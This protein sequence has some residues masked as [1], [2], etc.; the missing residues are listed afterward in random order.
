MKVAVIGAGSF[1]TCLALLLHRNGHSVKMWSHSK[2]TC[3]A[4]QEKRENIIYLPGYKIPNDINVSNS[5]EDT[6]SDVEL[7]LFVV[8]TQVTREVLKEA[9]K[10]LSEKVWVVSASKGIEKNT[11]ALV[12]DI[13]VQELGDDAKERLFFLSGPSFAKE[14]AAGMPTA[15]TLAG[16][17]ERLIPAVQNIF[18]GKTFRA[19]GTTDVIG[20]EIAGAMKNVIALA[21][22]ITDGL[23][24]GLNSRAAIMTRGLAEIAR[25]GKELGANPVTFMGLAGMGDLVLTCT[26]SLSRN[27]TVGLKLGEGKTLEEI[28]KD[29]RMVAEGVPTTQSAYEL[30][31]KYNV[32]MPITTLVYQVLYE[33]RNVRDA[34]EALMSRRLKFEGE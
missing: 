18:S 2:D 7:V 34:A 11:H 13:F 27:R 4:I 8:P 22:G 9:K 15:V 6:L 26:G 31:K 32:E 3:K 28:T 16:F 29:M 19:Y 25:L 12:S 24:F 20:V 30:S 33:N 23:G 5:L 14:V 1:G 21:T 10:F 17:E